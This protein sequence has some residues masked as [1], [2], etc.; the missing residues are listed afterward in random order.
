MV[1]CIADPLINGLGLRPAGWAGQ[2]GANI[3]RMR[4]GR[5]CRR[6]GKDARPTPDWLA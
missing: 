1:G 2:A 5:C 3:R 4:T 6:P